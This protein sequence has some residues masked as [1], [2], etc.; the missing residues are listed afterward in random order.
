LFARKF[1]CRRAIKVEDEN[2]IILKSIS[3]NINRVF[4]YKRNDLGSLMDSM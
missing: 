1:F 2:T 3:L 4:L